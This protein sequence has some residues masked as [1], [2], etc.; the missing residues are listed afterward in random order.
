MTKASKEQMAIRIERAAEL[1]EDPLATQADVVKELATE[2]G[3][4]SQQA[5][6]Y[7]RDGR[8]LLSNAFDVE[9]VRYRYDRIMNLLEVVNK[10]ALDAN[11]VNA[12]VGATKAMVNH[13]KRVVE[14]DEPAAWNRGMAVAYHD[15]STESPT[16]DF[17][18]N[19]EQEEDQESPTPKRQRLSDLD[20]L[21][22]DINDVDEIP[23]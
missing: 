7:V 1:L 5:R 16:E 4:T 17:D 15:D 11:N 18:D 19:N 6:T 8:K 12:A 9:G 21:D 2:F 3:V 10:A 20:S 22:Y 14:I 23:F 13:F